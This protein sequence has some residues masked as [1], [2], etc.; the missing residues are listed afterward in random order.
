MIWK[1]ISLAE[2][3]RGLL[4]RDGVL[5][6]ILRPGRHRL[7]DPF[8]RHSVE[9]HDVRKPVFMSEWGLVMEKNHPELF[10]RDLIV[11]RPAEGEAALIRLDGRPAFL[12]PFGQVKYLWTV[13]QEVKVETISI[14]GERRVPAHV[15]DTWAVIAGHALKRVRVEAHEAGLLKVDGRVTEVL[16][17]GRHAF[18]AIGRTVEFQV[19]EMRPRAI[20]VAA[21]EI[22][23]KDKVSVRL[24]L[25]AF[26]RITDPSRLV[27]NTPDAEAHIYRLVQFAAREAVGGRTLDAVLKDRAEID[28]E[29]AKQ[30]RERLGEIGIEI[31]ELRVK[32]VILP[33]DMRELLNKVVEA[34]KAAEANLI[35]RREETAATRS[36]LNTARLMDSHP[37]LMRLKEL[38][39]VE[40][41]TEKVGRIDI[42][43]TSEGAGLPALIDT[44][45]GGEA[46][47]A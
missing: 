41:L 4:M 8:G 15:A 9:R 1:L 24:T 13:L 29:I 27:A 16:A 5:A 46:S 39:A 36:L 10:E 35:R 37:A 45:I 20:E 22:L 43:Q 47:E 34:E 40:R 28:A 2:H 21:Q 14:E 32:D 11:V 26:A 31:V 38:E 6:D 44:L 3:E 7:F 17:P 25:T 33:G 12:V 18:W 23:T 30:V 42:R 19:L